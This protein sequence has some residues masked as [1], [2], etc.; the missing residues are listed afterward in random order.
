MPKTIPLSSTQENYALLVMGMHR[1]G[2]SALTRVCNLLGVPLGEDL[3]PAAKGNNDAGFWEHASIVNIHD[4][5]YDLL[6]SC[7]DDT[8]FLPE[9]WWNDIRVAPFLEEI[10]RTIEHDFADH[11][12]WA[13]KDPRLC[14]LLPLWK[15]VLQEL[16]IRPVCIL[17]MRHPLDVAMSL[18]QRDRFSVTKSLLL[19]LQHVLLAEKESRG[20]ARTVVYYD[21]LMSHPGLV[22]EHIAKNLAI[23][24]PVAYETASSEIGQFLKQELHHHRG[25]QGLPIPDEELSGWVNTLWESIGWIGTNKEPEMVTVFAQVESSLK[26]RLEAASVFMDDWIHE[27]IAERH[28]AMR[29]DRQVQ[30]IHHQNAV[31]HHTLAVKDQEFQQWQEEKHL[32]AKTI[33]DQKQA[34]QETQLLAANLQSAI[35]AL[36]RSTSWRI[37]RPIR[38]LKKALTFSKHFFHSGNYRRLLRIMRLWGIRG[39][40]HKIWERVRAEGVYGLLKWLAEQAKRDPQYDEWVQQYDTLTLQDRK[41]IQEH[42]KQFESTPLISVVMPVY[43]IDELWLR[44]AIE[45]VC[46]Q[47]YPHWELCIADDCSTK[48]HIQA[49]LREYQEKDPRIKVI[50]RTANGHIS[51]ASNSALAL[52]TGEFVA[53]LDHDD[54]LPEHALYYVAHEINQHPEVDL[55]YSDE[56]K[57]DQDGNRYGPYFKTEWNPDLFFSQNMF[58]HLGVYRLSLIEKIGGFRKGYEGSQDYDLCLRCLPFVK[59]EAIRHIPKV[60]YHWR[61]IPGSTALNIDSKNYAITAARLAMKD[62]FAK[63]YPGVIVEDAETRFGYHRIVWPMPKEEPKVSIIIPT[64]DNEK[65]L[66]QALES[67]IGKTDYENYEIIIVN[68]QSA[69]PNTLAYFKELETQPKIRVIEYAHPF[70][71]SAINNEAVR[72]A[73]GSVLAFV[74]DD[75]EVIDGE[76]LREMVSHALRPNVGAVGARLLFPGGL[77]I[78]HAGIVLGA[79][80]HRVAGHPLYFYPVQEVGYYARSILT[81]ALSAVTAACMVMRREIFEE[82]GGFNEVDL[83][84]AYNDVD[85]CLRIRE[86]GYDIIY[87]PFAE[88]YH[89]ESVTRGKD[90]S[91][92]RLKRFLSEVHYMR[93]RWGNVLDNDP[94]YSPN[95]NRKGDYTLAFP[96]RIGK[97]W[98]TYKKE[99]I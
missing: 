82:T 92:E 49:V 57:L 90:V 16:Q 66:R 3:M 75:I 17:S 87:T 22:T 72:H 96:P 41:Q 10:K 31:L 6:Q 42:I 71:F 98:L 62:F 32:C 51:E 29:L 95:L 54:M 24:W 7:W 2:T 86:K 84:V 88:L 20:M 61:A 89:H 79:G 65:I 46:R 35:E 81:H 5:V 9:H 76:W 63:H 14:R 38:L 69:N 25:T 59:P 58:S 94:Y 60:L 80:D 28:K 67:I 19:W 91:G 39:T 12:C 93:N 53:L 4:R 1:S 47:L 33:A 74:N 36:T 83:Q 50:Y 44:E 99:K 48:P 40:L 23:K 18:K 43:N 64:R 21:H 13:L 78:Q 15:S 8:R 52:A 97:P 27:T 30:A 34:L 68:N 73:T 85:F 77:R 45:S 55:I 26:K 11:H 56:D 37:T 70:N